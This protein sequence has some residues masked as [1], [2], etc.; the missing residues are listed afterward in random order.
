MYD[1]QHIGFMQR[2]S[3]FPSPS[4]SRSLSLS[5]FLS[6]VFLVKGKVKWTLVQALRL[7]TGRTAHRRSRGIALYFHDNGTR[8]DEGSASRSGRSLFPGKIRYPLYR[9][10]GGP[11][12][13][14]GP[15]QK[16]SAPPGFDPRTVQPVASRYTDWTTRPTAFLVLLI[17]RI[18][19]LCQMSGK[20]PSGEIWELRAGVDGDSNFLGY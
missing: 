10:L 14:S 12:G 15:V 1:I 6:V 2:Q 17:P 16:I 9:R 7:C 11:Q 8:R 13:R 20:C 3:K 5:L 4:L 19:A 18:A